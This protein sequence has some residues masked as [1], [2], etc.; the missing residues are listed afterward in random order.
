MPY[1][2]TDEELAGLSTEQLLE[3]SDANIQMS[4][5]LDAEMLRRGILQET[6]D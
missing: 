4:R 3:L 2:L 5:R 1:N 6:G